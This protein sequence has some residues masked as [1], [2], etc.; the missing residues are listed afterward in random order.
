M[1]PICLTGNGTAGEDGSG[2][3]FIYKTFINGE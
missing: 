1:N 3:N 2:I